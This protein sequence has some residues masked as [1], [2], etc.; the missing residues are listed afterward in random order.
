MQ[1]TPVIAIALEGENVITRMRDLLGPT[2]SNVADPGTIRG[3]LGDKS[4]DSKMRNVC[5]ASDSPEA[6][7]VEIKRFFEA[8]EVFSF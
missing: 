6:A 7:A 2:D 8:D 3:D 5:H 1:E 4:G